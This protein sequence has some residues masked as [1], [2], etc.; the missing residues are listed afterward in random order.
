MG[1][2]REGGDG[3]Q[4]AALT[5]GLLIERERVHRSLGDDG[6]VAVILGEDL[7]A[8]R[9]SE[10]ELESATEELIAYVAERP[11]PH[12]MAVWALTKTYDSRAGTPLAELLERILGDA[13]REHLA[14]Q[15][16]VGLANLGDD[17][18]L[19]VIR[20]AARDGHGKVGETAREYLH[21]RGETE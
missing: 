3:A 2:I 11:T 20:R 9:L 15:A 17:R 7:A 21:A 5:L 1:R 6:G 10:S 8:Q 4:E 19:Q 12:P 13:D 16:L 14:Y 18:F